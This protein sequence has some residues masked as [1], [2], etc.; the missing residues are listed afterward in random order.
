MFRYLPILTTK[1]R[2]YV[3]KT[4]AFEI[5]QALNSDEREIMHDVRCKEIIR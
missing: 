2:L 1:H 5:D 4:R 3:D